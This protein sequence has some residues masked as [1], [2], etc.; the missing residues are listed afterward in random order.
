MDRPTTCFS[1]SHWQL[2]FCWNIGL[3][4]NACMFVCACRQAFQHGYLGCW[5]A[6][7]SRWMVCHIPHRRY[8]VCHANRQVSVC[9]HAHFPG[10]C[11]SRILKTYTCLQMSSHGKSTG[12]LSRFVIILISYDVCA[13]RLRYKPPKLYKLFEHGLGVI[14]LPQKHVMNMVARAHMTVFPHGR[15]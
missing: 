8:Q 6:C 2:A 9:C 3:N 14:T 15:S 4:I 11:Q 13:L 10:P 12:P 1:Q 5:R 7:R